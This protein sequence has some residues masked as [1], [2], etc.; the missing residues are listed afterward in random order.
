MMASEDEYGL[1]AKM[2]EIIRVVHKQGG[3]MSAHEI[4]KLTG[5]S[6]ATVKK[7]IAELLKGEVLIVHGEK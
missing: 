4:S 7:Y 1:N 5:F 3:A 6:Y 2:R